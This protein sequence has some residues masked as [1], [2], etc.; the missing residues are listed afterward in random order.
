MSNNDIS[1]MFVKHPTVEIAAYGLDEKKRIK[2]SHDVF[3]QL[4][5]SPEKVQ[6]FMKIYQQ[7]RSSYE[8]LKEEGLR[9]SAL[10]TWNKEMRNAASGTCFGVWR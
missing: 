9:E 5:E 4:M 8:K 2:V 1:R 6:L 7:A 3:N 10:S